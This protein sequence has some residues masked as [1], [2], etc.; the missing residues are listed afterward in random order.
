MV[1]TDFTTSVDIADGVLTSRDGKIIA[2]G[3]ANIGSSPAN[4][5]LARYVVGPCCPVEAPHRRRSGGPTAV[6]ASHPHVRVA[7]A[8]DLTRPSLG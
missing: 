5:A 8:V 2:A 1:V 3:T 6:P 7:C 4:F